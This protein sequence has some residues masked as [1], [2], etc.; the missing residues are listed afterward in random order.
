MLGRGFVCQAESSIEGGAL[1]IAEIA[2]APAHRPEQ[3]MQ[4]RKRQVSLRLH[5]HRRKN[6]HPPLA[7]STRRLLEQPGLAY[8]GLAAKDERPPARENIVQKRLQQSLLL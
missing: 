8:T 7:R 4:P 6:R 3:L 1:H 2:R 5:T